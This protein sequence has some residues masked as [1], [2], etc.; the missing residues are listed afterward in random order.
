MKKKSRMTYM[1]L[2]LSLVLCLTGCKGKTITSEPQ[3]SGAVTPQ[4]V[5]VTEKPAIQTV[6]RT[7]TRT[8]VYLVTEYDKNGKVLS[9]REFNRNGGH[10]EATTYTYD[11]NG[12][13]LTKVFEKSGK[14]VSYV[15]KNY[16]NDG[17]L[18]EEYKGDS[19][20]T[21]LLQQ[22]YKYE[23]GLLKKEI[24]YEDDGSVW[25]Y[26]NYEY[27][28]DGLLQLKTKN[29]DDDYE[30]R[31]WIYEYDEN[32]ILS[33]V[34]DE[35][36]NHKQISFYDEQGN[37]VRSD[38]YTADDK[39]S[40]IYI[41]VFGPFGLVEDYRY[42]SDGKEEYHGKI[43]YDANGNR[44]KTVEVD[45][46]GNETVEGIYEYDDDGNLIHSENKNGYY[47]YDA[48]YNEF[49]DP[50]MTHNVCKDPTRSAG[51]YDDLF[52]Y[53]YTYYQ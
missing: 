51:T 39:L 47:V 6:K 4:V 35:M 1:V 30:Y 24:W 8:R 27:N 15:K 37:V 13:L 45:K 46:K 28:D 20:D 38:Y 17:N 12:N 26:Y 22:E 33:S 19:K 40:A 31:R 2:L 43:Y 42:D 36:Y 25:E 23:S 41:N 52:E 16:D 29:G 21:L 5:A 3:S 14:T 18:I 44:M 34:T 7:D 10:L 11:T 9:E 50:I 53:E 49:G 32:G 48:E